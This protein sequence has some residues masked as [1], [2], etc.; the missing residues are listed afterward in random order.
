MSHFNQKIGRNFD[1]IQDNIKGESIQ[2]VSIFATTG[3]LNDQTGVSN[4]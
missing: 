3:L 2:R 4:C 1:N